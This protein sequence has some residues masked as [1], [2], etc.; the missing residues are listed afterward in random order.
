MSYFNGASTT[1]FS[2]NNPTGN[3]SPEI[4]SQRVLM[5]FRTSSVVEGITN[6]D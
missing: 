1:N 3:F 6:N 2:G 4:F 5:F